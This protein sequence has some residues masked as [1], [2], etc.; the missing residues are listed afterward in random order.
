MSSGDATRTVLVTTSSFGRHDGAPLRRLRDSGLRVV[1]NPHGR[2]L[3]ESE[4]GALI[5]RH[6]PVGVIAGV[7]PLTADVL[8]QS[9][10]LK[11]ISRCGVGLDSVDVGAAARMGVAVTNTPDAP[12]IPVAE[13]TVGLMLALLRG[14]HLSD[15]GVRQGR[16]HRPMGGLLFGKTVGIIGCGRIGACVA[17]LLAPFQCDVLGCDLRP[18]SDMPAQCRPV[19]LP[20]LLSEADIVTLHIPCSPENRHLIN[21]ERLMAMKE[22]ACLINAARGGLVD[23]AALYGALASGKMGG[24]ALDTFEEEP[25]TGPL[26]KL[27]NVLL[28]SHIGS[29]AAEGRVMM[30]TQAVDRLLGV[31]GRFHGQWGP[32][33]EGR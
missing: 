25:Y 7:E 20:R 21:A 27:E 10:G 23:E 9:T 17:A 18:S 12:V 19:A 5:R 3:T 8:G 14:I 13:L 29:Y 6:A 22:G 28:T 24:A 30:E 33:P 32:T 26:A 15:A 4:V 11:V 31:L 2:R 1:L 16:W